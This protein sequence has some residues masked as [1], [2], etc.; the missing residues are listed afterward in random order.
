MA[1]FKKTVATAKAKLAKAESKAFAARLE[2][3]DA[4]LQDAAPHAASFRAGD[5]RLV[6]GGPSMPDERHDEPLKVLTDQRTAQRRETD[7]DV[8]ARPKRRS[9][10]RHMECSDIS[11]VRSCV[12]GQGNKPATAARGTSVE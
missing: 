2:S 8:T 3:I 7:R 12:A 11:R 1:D 4:I 6:G 9:H 5:K 10:A